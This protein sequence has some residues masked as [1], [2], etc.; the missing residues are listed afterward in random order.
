MPEKS[1]NQ[2]E[3]SEHHVSS[4]GMT[5]G[6]IHFDSILDSIKTG[7]KLILAGLD[8]LTFVRNAIMASLSNYYSPRFSQK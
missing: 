8:L 1:V 4:K 5:P 2:A 7:E 6:W 3:N